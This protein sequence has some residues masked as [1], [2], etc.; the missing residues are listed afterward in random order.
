MKKDVFM[1]LTYGVR[2]YDDYFPLKEDCSGPI[3]FDKGLYYLKGLSVTSGLCITRCTQPTNRTEK[4]Q[5]N[6]GLVT[7]QKI[8]YSAYGGGP[9]RR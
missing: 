2:I 8:L 6:I 3:F 5:Q 7:N 1:R 9:M 4:S